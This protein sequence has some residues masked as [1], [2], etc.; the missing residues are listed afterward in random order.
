VKQG[1][2]YKVR[3]THKATGNIFIELDIH[4]LLLMLAWERKVQILTPL[5]SVNISI[6]KNGEQVEISEFDLDQEG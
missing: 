1:T 5:E 4:Q 3:V 2:D 6:E